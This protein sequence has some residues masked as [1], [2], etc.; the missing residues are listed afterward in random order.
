MI[1]H[2]RASISSLGQGS[3][4]DRKLAPIVLV[5]SRKVAQWV[6]RTHPG[7]H[8]RFALGHL[9]EELADPISRFFDAVSNAY[10]KAEEALKPLDKFSISDADI[11]AMRAI[12][13][14]PDPA[15]GMAYPEGTGFWWSGRARKEWEAIVEKG[16]LPDKEIDTLLLDILVPVEQALAEVAKKAIA[17]KDVISSLISKL[18]K[19]GSWVA[20]KVD[21]FGSEN[22]KKIV[23]TYSTLSSYNSKNREFVQAVR[24]LNPSSEVQDLLAGIENDLK[25]SE[26]FQKNMEVMIQSKGLPLDQVKKEAGLGYYQWLVA[27][28]AVAVGSV[29]V[30]HI[31]AVIIVIAANLATWPFIEYILMGVWPRWLRIKDAADREKLREEQKKTEALRQ[32]ISQLE[33]QLIVAGNG[34]KKAEDTADKFADLWPNILSAKK[35]EDAKERG[36]ILAGQKRTNILP[37]ALGGA[38]LFGIG[39][40]LMA[41]KK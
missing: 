11:A 27:K 16:L 24:N 26:A 2:E 30:A 33:E 4:H 8:P 5:P 41:K 34:A 17:N 23:E 38:A 7:Q 21:F 1:V 37:Y 40:L 14:Q 19:V 31:I 12:L 35:V 28:I 10:N 18:S 13:G 22:W 25:K 20:A 6:L 36:L 9:G 39:L 29:V 15:K 3:V 32:R